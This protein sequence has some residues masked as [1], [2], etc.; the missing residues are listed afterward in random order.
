MDT[1]SNVVNLVELT[2]DGSGLWTCLNTVWSAKD[3]CTM[4]YDAN[5][6]D[7]VGL[8]WLCQAITAS[9]ADLMC[10]KWMLHVS[11]LD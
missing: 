7:A 10:W 4:L 5:A 8:L 2:E 1:S 11:M 6:A 3:F 9:L